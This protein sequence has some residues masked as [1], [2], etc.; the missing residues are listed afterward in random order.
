LECRPDVPA[1]TRTR[2]YAELA[3]A[4]QRR[5]GIHFL[6]ETWEGESLVDGM[7]G[8]SFDLKAKR[9]WVD[10]RTETREAAHTPA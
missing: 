1:D 9:R 7:T 4:I 8:I 5:V 3:A 6:V 10:R 2:L